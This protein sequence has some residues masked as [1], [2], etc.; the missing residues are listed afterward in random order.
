[1]K[2]P[3][4]AESQ[5]PMPVLD[6]FKLELELEPKIN[7]KCSFFRVNVDGSLLL[8]KR[9]VPDRGIFKCSR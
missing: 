8:V 9:E 5:F 7:I 6:Q 4:Q 1:M 2:W 3:L